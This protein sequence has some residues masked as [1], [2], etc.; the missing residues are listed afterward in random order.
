MIGNGK[1]RR[2]NEDD[3][4]LPYDITFEIIGNERCKGRKIKAHK[5]ILAVISPVFKRMFYGALKETR[6]VIPIEQTT[7]DAFEK[8]IDFFY[9]VDIDYKSMGVLELF[10]MVNLAEQYDVPKLMRELIVGLTMVPLTMQNFMEVANIASKFSQFEDASSALLLHC[11]KYFHEKV[12][13]REPDEQMKFMAAQ[14]REG[15]GDVALEL[16]TLAESM[17]PVVCD[18]CHEKECLVGMEVPPEKLFSGQHVKA[19]HQSNYWNKDLGY[20]NL[21]F[22][23]IKFDRGSYKVTLKA[24]DPA[25]RDGNYVLTTAAGGGLRG[26]GPYFAGKY[27]GYYGTLVYD[28]PL[29]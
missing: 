27:G 13:K 2:S 10:D 11:A 16:L 21:R 6:N 3:S 29:E 18:N 5:S 26:V 22:S 25:Y 14:H 20:Q 28:C 8:L 9:H 12:I 19:N 1:S 7:A 15:R 23:V 24:K 17:T 4:D